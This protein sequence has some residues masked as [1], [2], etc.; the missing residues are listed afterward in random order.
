MNFL[1]CNIRLN[2]T[3]RFG[4]AEHSNQTGHFGVLPRVGEFM[5]FRTEAHS[6][7]ERRQIKSIVWVE[8]A[9]NNAEGEPDFYP[10]IELE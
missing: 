10:Q 5:M 7:P 8:N 1:R 9:F 6:Q 4:E 3:N 2:W